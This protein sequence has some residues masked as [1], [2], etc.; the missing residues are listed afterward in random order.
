MIK[1]VLAEDQGMLLG[2]M[3]ALINM[4]DDM[5]VVAAARNGVEALEAIRLYQSDIIIMDI[6]M[7]EKTGLDVVEEIK[8]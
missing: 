3:Q 2:A 1:I 4:E 5:E 6:E 8:G 7:P